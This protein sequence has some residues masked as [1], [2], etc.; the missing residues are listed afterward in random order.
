MELVYLWVE[1]YKNIEKQEF[2]F[3]P[4]FE[5]KFYDEYEIDEDGKE[6]LKDNCK[7]EIKPKKHQSIFPDNMNITAIVGENGSGKSNL[8]EILSN[9]ISDDKLTIKVF[10]DGSKTLYKT[11]NPIKINTKAIKQDI[12]EVTV[13]YTEI[14]SN[15]SIDNQTITNISLWKELQE[16]NYKISE[17]LNLI[18]NKMQTSHMIFFQE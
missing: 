10:H 6:K 2:N 14:P 4:R 1:K 9:Y 17:S 12:S 3:S 16:N 13:L 15:N 5:C 11:N 18:K 8:L 7:L